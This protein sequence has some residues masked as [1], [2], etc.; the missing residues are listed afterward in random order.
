MLDLRRLRLLRELRERGTVTA[1]ADAFNYTPSA[2]SQQLAALER[3]AGVALTE[4]VGR[5]VR[6]TDAGRALAH[7][8]DGGLAR[9]EHAEAELAAAAS[10]AVRGRVRVSAFQTAARSLVAPVMR[11]L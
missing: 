1:V 6:L 11:P 5:G 2:V 9:L 3:E 7:H 8:T 4:R 10:G